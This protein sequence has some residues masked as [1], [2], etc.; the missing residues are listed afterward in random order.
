MKAMKSKDVKD[1]LEGVGFRVTGT[2]RQEFASLMREDIERWE[3]VIKATGF[4]IQE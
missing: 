2:S 4:K 1:K 3:K